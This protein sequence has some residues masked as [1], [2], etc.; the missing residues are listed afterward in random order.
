[1]IADDL[2]PDIRKAFDKKKPFVPTN[3]ADVRNP[4]VAELL[5]DKD[6]KIFKAISGQPNILFGRRGSGKTAY[7]RSEYFL[8]N[9]DF[10]IELRMEGL[11]AKV[12]AEIEKNMRGAVFAESVAEIWSTLFH[13]VLFDKVV[14]SEVMSKRDLSLAR[15][16]I[17]KL[18]VRRGKTPDDFLWNVVD[19]VSRRAG[20]GTIGIIAE[21]I[22]SLDNVSFEDARNQ[23]F[24]AMHKAHVSAILMIDS[25]DGLPLNANNVPHTIS[26]LLKCLGRFDGDASSFHVRCCIPTEYYHAFMRLSSNPN[27]DFEDVAILQWHARELLSVAAHRL[28]LYGAVHDIGIDSLTKGLNPDNKQEAKKIVFSIF[29]EVVENN[30]GQQEGTL[31]YLV[32][33]TQLLPRQLLRYLN[34]IASK[35]LKDG[36]TFHPISGTEVVAGIAAIE[37]SIAEEIFS[38]YQAIY[39]NAREACDRA[40]P[41]LPRK[42]KHGDLLRVFTRFAR[43]AL[44][45][46]DLY[47][48]RRMLIEMGIVGR[49]I[50]E[51]EQ[52]IQ[53]LFEYTLPHRLVVGTSDEMCLHPIFSAGRVKLPA[54]A[55]LPKPVYPFGS[56]IDGVEWRDWDSDRS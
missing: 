52:Y 36:G 49:V 50:G 10:I 13:V 15:D 37:G 3:A 30:L 18:G 41:E 33:H 44:P 26:G 20:N 48:F 38:A 46:F 55:G 56:D 53:G 16:F 43:K 8:R 9:Y 12:L 24:R 29:P 34:Q 42:F 45:E 54:K 4:K 6:N 7:L 25:V 2:I 5:F 28:Q 27:K 1:M 31:A 22:R 21:V 51:T 11:F 14:H 40:I 35:H 17:A 32:R 39:P 19:A 23:V 47:D